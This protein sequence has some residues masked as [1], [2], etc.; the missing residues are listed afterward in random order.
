MMLD[1]DGGCLSPGTK[2]H[3][4]EHCTASFRS[5]YHLRRHVL[6]HTGIAMCRF[7]TRM[8]STAVG[9]SL[10]NCVHHFFLLASE[11]CNYLSSLLRFISPFLRFRLISCY[12]IIVSS[13]NCQ[14]TELE[15]WFKEWNI[16]W[17]SRSIDHIRHELCFRLYCFV[18]V[19]F[20]FKLER[21]LLQS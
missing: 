10:I 11:L 20:L 17:R 15:N 2:P 7:S 3:I 12:I 8:L 18:L 5:S 21:V 6:I 13:P 16:S 19:F 1:G 4:C 14:F 9:Q